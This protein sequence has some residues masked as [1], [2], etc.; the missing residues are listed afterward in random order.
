MPTWMLEGFADYVALAHAGV[1]LDKAAGQELAR[2]KQQGIP[3]HLP[4]TQ[5][6]SPSATGLGEPRSRPSPR[7]RRPRSRD[8]WSRS[9]RPRK[10]LQ[11]I[12]RAA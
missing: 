10:E 7:R 1:P 4:T 8:R 11:W 3:D 2:M 5:E 9:G 12:R 6:L